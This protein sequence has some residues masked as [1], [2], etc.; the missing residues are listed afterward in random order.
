[1][2]AL[3]PAKLNLGLE[4]VGR[5][6]DG[7]HELATIMQTVT[8]ADRLTLEAK[9]PLEDGATAPVVVTV[10]DPALGEA[11]EN[12]ARRALLALQAHAGTAIGAEAHLEKRIPV[13]AGLGGASADAAAALLAG[14]RLWDL[15]IPADDL[16]GLAANLGSDVPFLLGGGTALVTGRGETV[17]PVRPLRD[18]WFVVVTPR[19]AAPI[20]RKTAALYAALLPGDYASGARVRAHAERLDRGGPLDPDALANA[21]TRALY[22]LRPEL[23]R[24]ARVLLGS[25]APWATLSG[26]GPSHYTAVP[27]R[28][29]ADE[30]ATA[31]ARMAGP[32]DAIS[33]CAPHLG[34]PPVRHGG[35]ESDPI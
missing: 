19:P 1:V 18:V 9:E 30:I 33:V 6:P 15:D 11:K 14:C 10:D 4:V 25:G 24:G 12:L 17:V 29:V 22:G 21:F 8:L 34:P 16:R 3:A 35:L 2:A 13:A 26:S 27:L 32:S 20:P 5:R 7:Y 23:R 31:A 28:S